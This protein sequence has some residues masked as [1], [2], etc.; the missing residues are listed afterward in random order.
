M[1][2]NYELKDLLELAPAGG[3][4]P[5]PRPGVAYPPGW[6]GWDLK[7]VVALLAIAER[8]E[9]TAELLQDMRDEIAAWRLDIK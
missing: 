4:R 2:Y 8:V 6:P 3:C 1:P 9:K 7:Q 5:A